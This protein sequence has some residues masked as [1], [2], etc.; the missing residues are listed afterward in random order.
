M[1]QYADGSAA[2]TYRRSMT[3]E[4]RTPARGG[5]WADRLRAFLERDATALA[6]VVPRLR[7]YPV[8]RTRGWRW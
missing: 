7:D 8:S 3:I 6:P 2:P 1:Q 5:W 4:L